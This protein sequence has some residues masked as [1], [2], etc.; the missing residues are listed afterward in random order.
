MWNAIFVQ[1]WPWWAGGAALGSFV[2]LYALVF[3]RLMGMS[4]T[5]ENAV[6]ELREPITPKGETVSLD[7]AVLNLA[8]EQ[9]LDLAELGIRVPAAGASNAASASPLVYSPR[10]IVAGLILGAV[11]GCSLSGIT[12]GFSLGPT[13]D[14][15]FRIAPWAQALLLTVGGFAAGLGARM[16]GGCPSGHGLGGMSML[17]PGSFVA[18]AG[19]F[20]SGIALTFFLRYAL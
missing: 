10:F 3:N 1:P 20:T 19:Y 5:V 11:V 18:I 9:G 4:G 7:D 16:A 15:L 8:R 14:S 13:Y 12:P 2:V 6:R 17:S